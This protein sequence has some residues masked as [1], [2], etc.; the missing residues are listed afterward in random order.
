M[1]TASIFS[2]GSLSVVIAMLSLV[3]AVA[4]LGIT[5]ASKKKRDPEESENENGN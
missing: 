4:S 2:G 1:Y 5:L 3:V